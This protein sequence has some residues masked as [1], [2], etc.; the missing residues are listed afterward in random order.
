MNRV[1]SFIVILLALVG[2]VLFV[3]DRPSQGAA[4]SS[5]PNQSTDKKQ[6]FTGEFEMHETL[7]IVGPLV[8]GY[9]GTSEIDLKATIPI[10]VSWDEK[11][12][13]WVIKG[14]V[15]GAKGTTTQ[16]GAYGFLCQGTTKGRVDIKGFVE[17]EKLK[18]CVFKLE[19]NQEWEK[20][21]MTCHGG[22]PPLFLKLEHPAFD[23]NHVFDYETEGTQHSKPV[24]SGIMKGHLFLQLK[25]F[26]GTLID[27]CGVM[28]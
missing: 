16:T 24:E 8:S 28:Y 11:I 25:K 4:G 21:F 27:G 18:A 5:P 23:L 2:L 22:K 14:S 7:S 9:R 1:H 6:T 12:G 20:H 17:S 3:A 19:I 26:S 10:I 13:A 15:R